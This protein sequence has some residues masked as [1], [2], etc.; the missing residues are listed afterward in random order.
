MNDQIIDGLVKSFVQNFDIDDLSEFEKFERFCAYS[1][2]NKEFL[3]NL[4]SNDLEDFSVGDN[5]GIDSMAFYVNGQLVKNSDEFIQIREQ[6]KQNIIVKMYVIQS[7]RSDKFENAQVAN[8][9]DTL[10]DFLQ[11]KP[12]YPITTETQQF[13]ELY[14]SIISDFAAIKEIN[15]ICYFCSIGSWNG[16]TTFSATIQKRSDQ[17]DSMG[18]FESIKIEPV[19][20]RTLI[21]Q[22]KKT[23]NPLLSSF[24]FQHKI[25]IKSITGVDEAYIGHIPFKELTKLIIDPENK[26]LRNLFYD[27]VRD[28]LG[29]DNDVNNKIKQTLEDKEFSQFSLFNNGITIIAEENKGKQDTFILSNFQIVNGCQT[30]NVLYECRDIQGIDDAIIPIKLVITKDESLRDKIILSTNSQSKIEKEG[31][32]ALTY[33]QKQL[34]EYYVSAKDGLF[35][36]RRSNQYSNRADVYKKCIVDIREQIKSYVAM[37][38]EEP[39]VVS[40]YFGKVYK[41]REGD[42]FIE[43][44]LYE[45]YYVSGLL[46]YRFKDFL[47]SRDIKRKYNKARYHV[48]MLFR[49]L[50]ESEP[51]QKSFVSTKKKKIY[52]DSLI[53]KIRDKKQC[54]EYLKRVF[55]ILDNSNI[56][57][58]NPKLMYLKTTT[59]D[60]ID[61]LHRIIPK[62]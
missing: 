5:K 44:H 46:Q 29:F 33:F 28:F 38:L 58:D 43:Q 9:L 35:Y 60:Y 49:M 37:F 13:H 14:L 39:H 36:E 54:L 50:V 25:Q 27:N 23:T 18:L 34:E 41:D 7:K 47:N 53:E 4:S 21:H 16:N 20:R 17:L 1:L 59:Q 2:L 61:T 57:N 31:L 52:F 42:I 15:L 26:T 62:E 45:P 30:S 24:E 11:E 12:S 6:V 56:D 32:L 22:Y 51:F 8:F 10:I 3:Y 48:F 55:E 40:G 19:D